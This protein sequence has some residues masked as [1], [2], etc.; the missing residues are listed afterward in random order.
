MP[1]GIDEAD[2]DAELACLEDEWAAEG[3][4]TATA[5][6]DATFEFDLPAQPNQQ[7]SINQPAA[8]TRQA[9]PAVSTN[10]FV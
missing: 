8:A 1:D 2:L 10:S 3:E 4:A 6:A 7:V 5:S 9:N